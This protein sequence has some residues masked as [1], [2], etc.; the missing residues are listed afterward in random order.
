MLHKAWSSI[1]EMHYCF[2]GSSIKFQGH[3]WQK[4]TIFF[5][6]CAFPDCNSSLNLQMAMRCCTKLETATEMPYSLQGHP[7][8]FKV[9]W[10]KTSPILTQIGCFQTIGQSK[11]SNPSDMTCLIYNPTF[12]QL[13]LLSQV[14]T[15]PQSYK[16]G[17]KYA[18]SYYIGFTDNNVDKII[19]LKTYLFKART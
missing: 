4:I 10:D 3:M 6:N 19:S 1:G 11:L 15:P 18:P 13:Q 8:N 5:T 17:V 16:R 12:N 14:K 9:A 2:S 7:S